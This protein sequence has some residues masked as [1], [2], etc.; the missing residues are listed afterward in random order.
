MLASAPKTAVG[1]LNSCT[2][3]PPVDRL[4]RATVAPP[5]HPAVRS[6]PSSSYLEMALIPMAPPGSEPLP[7]RRPLAEEFRD[8]NATRRRLARPMAPSDPTSP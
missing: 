8:V 3:A 4:H 5:A 7:E 1:N 2:F 6:G